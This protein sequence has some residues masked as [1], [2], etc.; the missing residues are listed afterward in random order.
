MKLESMPTSAQIR[1]EANKILEVLEERD[2]AIALQKGDRINS[3]TPY[4]EWL[5]NG[6]Q[7]K[8]YLRQLAESL[9][10]ELQRMNATSELKMIH[11]W[12][13]RGLLK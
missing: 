1:I 13:L 10:F 6:D 3:Y 12:I 9:V 7:S 2:L 4:V 5:K 11:D 8:L